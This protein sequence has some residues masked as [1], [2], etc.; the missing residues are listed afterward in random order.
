MR[1][2]LPRPS[3][4]PLGLPRGEGLGS[5]RTFERGPHAKVSPV[6]R[7]NRT[8]VFHVKHF[9]TIGGRKDRTPARH[10]DCI[11]DEI[12]CPVW[13]DVTVSRE[14]NEYG[15]CMLQISDFCNDLIAHSSERLPSN[16]APIGDE[17]ALDKL[18]RTTTPF[19]RVRR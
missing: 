5:G 2:R 8:K 12:F 10:E 18:A 19:F 9:G 17:C 6:S 7:L 4:Q 15:P 3:R 11:L 1:A 16:S 13:G 14:R